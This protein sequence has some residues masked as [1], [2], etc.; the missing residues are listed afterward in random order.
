M[1]AFPYCYKFD[2][3]LVSNLHAQWWAPST[4]STGCWMSTQQCAN[5]APATRMQP[6][7][8][9][10]RSEQSKKAP[11]LRTKNARGSPKKHCGFDA[12]SSPHNLGSRSA[13]A[14]LAQAICLS[15]SYK[16]LYFTPPTPAPTQG[17]SAACPPSTT[18]PPPPPRAERRPSCWLHLPG[19]L[20]A[21][22]AT[23][24]LMV[25]T[26]VPALRQ[27]TAGLISSMRTCGDAGGGGG[28]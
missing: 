1:W 4:C 9:H 19:Q 24:A 10:L 8:T 18:L 3:K 14:T 23:A 7:D 17:D 25:A 28:R 22:L 21:H 5:A 13:S 15:N 6:Y 11:S 2:T 26:L 20:H 16:A 27:S 12:C